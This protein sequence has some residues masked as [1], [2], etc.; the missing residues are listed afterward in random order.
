MWQNHSKCEQVRDIYQSNYITNLLNSHICLRIWLQE[1]NIIIEWLLPLNYVGRWYQ[2]VV[3]NYPCQFELYLDN[4]IF[5]SS[6]V[7][8]KMTGEKKN[9]SIEI[10][11]LANDKCHTSHI[12]F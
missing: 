12:V 4:N 9:W 6:P 2:T 5:Y 10:N 8:I 1:T 7:N 3:E 11:I